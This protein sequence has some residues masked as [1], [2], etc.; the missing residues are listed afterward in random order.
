[1]PANEPVTIQDGTGFYTDAD[2]WPDSAENG[3]GTYGPRSYGPD[4]EN[5]VDLDPDE[6]DRAREDAEYVNELMGC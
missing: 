2:A 6:I 5:T 1:M 4:A 3:N